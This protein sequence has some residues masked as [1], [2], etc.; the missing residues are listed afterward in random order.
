MKRGIKICLALAGTLF[1]L[2]LTL[3]LVGAAMGGRRESNRY[4]QERWDE[5]SHDGDWGPILVGSDGVHIGGANGI[6]VD[7]DGVNIG[8]EHGIHVGHNGVGSYS[9]EKQLVESGEL[10]GIT[11]VDV[12]MDCGDVYLREGTEISVSLE[13]NLE[14][15]TMTYRVEN[16]V[17]KVEDESWEGVKLGDNFNMDCKATLTIPAG[18]ALDEL[19]LSTEFGDIEVDA[20]ITAKEADLSTSMGDISCRSLQAKELDAKSDMGDVILHLPGGREEYNWDLETNMGTLTVDG[21]TQSSG[22]GDIA[23]LGGYG[24]NYVTAEAAMGDIQVHFSK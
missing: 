18:T 9:G 5:I 20:A 16:G 2:G 14:H 24:P 8:G 12:D 15:Y 3:N 13:W 7:S 11:A 6:H 1:V 10:T 22:M 4:F 19:D 23:A 21:Q 17:L